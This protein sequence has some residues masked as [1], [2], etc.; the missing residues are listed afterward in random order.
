[1]MM[2]GKGK[3]GDSAHLKVDTRATLGK[4]SRYSFLS[5][6]ATGAQS[7]NRGTKGPVLFCKESRKV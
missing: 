1:M 3:D 6:S 5:A 4:N 7:Y 2:I